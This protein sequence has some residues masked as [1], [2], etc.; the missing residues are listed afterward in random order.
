MGGDPRVY[1]LHYDKQV[2]RAVNEFEI[3]M[4]FHDTVYFK[5]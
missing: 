4:I 5:L 3:E 2:I 1:P